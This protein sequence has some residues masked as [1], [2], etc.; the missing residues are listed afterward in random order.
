VDRTGDAFKHGNNAGTS[1]LG[2]VLALLGDDHTA[3][4]STAAHS[5]EYAMV[6]AMMPILNPAGVQEIPPSAY[7]RLPPPN[8]CTSTN[9]VTGSTAAKPVRSVGPFPQH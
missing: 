3:E 5:S 4:S 1:P 7:R 9:R 6:D 8:F 2:G